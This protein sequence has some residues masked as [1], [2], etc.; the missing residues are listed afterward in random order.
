MSLTRSLWGR[1]V[2]PEGQ[3]WFL[4]KTSLSM[5][6]RQKGSMGIGFLLYEGLLYAVRSAYAALMMQSG[7]I[8]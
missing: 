7:I 8:T 1:K 3:T 5:P 2:L 4:I 6:N